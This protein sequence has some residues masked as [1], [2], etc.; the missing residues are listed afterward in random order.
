M[1]RTLPRASRKSVGAF[2]VRSHSN[3]CSS[4]LQPAVDT[5]DVV[6]AIK[7]VIEAENDAIDQYNTIIRMCDGIDYVT[8]DL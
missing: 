7:G 5:T 6:A 8:Q 3:R 2:P 1:H 4:S